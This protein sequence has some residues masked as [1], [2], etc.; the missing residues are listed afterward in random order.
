VWDF[1]DGSQING[2]MNPTFA[3]GQAG[4]YNVS[5]RASNSF[6]CSATDNLTVT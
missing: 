2:V 3:Y 1:G 6:G 5:V 4:V